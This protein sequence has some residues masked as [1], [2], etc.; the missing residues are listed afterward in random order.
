MS[1][2][3]GG[4]C[5]QCGGAL[6]AEDYARSESCP[7]CGSDTRACRNCVNCDAKSSSECREAAAEPVQDRTRA[8]YCEH[9]SPASP[10]PAGREQAAKKDD[11][12]TS[13]EKLF[14]KK[15]E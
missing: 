2:H 9:F 14:G 8:N 13:F 10:K 7:R 5:W 3:K 12:K 1:V 11:A 15:T 6:E 4:T